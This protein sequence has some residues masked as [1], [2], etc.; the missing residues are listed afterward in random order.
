MVVY[1]ALYGDSRCFV[2][3]YEMFA[4]VVDRNKY[5]N[6]AQKFRFEMFHKPQLG[7]SHTMKTMKNSHEGLMDDVDADYADGKLEQ[8]YQKI[9]GEE[10]Q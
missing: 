2:R 8:V 3:P 7:R 5:P 9:M 1:E 4:S 6:A 10:N